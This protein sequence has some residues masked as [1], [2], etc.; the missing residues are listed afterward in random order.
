M[1][2]THGQGTVTIPA[3]PQRVVVLGLA[4]TQ[5]ATALGATIVG[6]TINPSS[7][8]GAWPGVSPQVRP[9]LRTLDSIT[10]NLEA[11][12]GLRPDLILM[13]TAQPSFSAAY[14]EISA[15]APTV[16][17]RTELLQDPGEELVR[18]IGHAL[19]RD[20]EA[21]QLIDR[22]SAT[23][24][25]FRTRHPELDGARY[26]FGQ[27][28]Q[29]G[30]YLVVSPGSPVTALFGDIGLELPA[31]IAGLPVQQAATTQVA[32]E[33]L[34]VLDSADIVF[35]GVG[36]DSDRTAFLSQPLVAASAPARAGR[37]HF[38]TFDQAGLLFQP[39]PANTEAVLGLLE[40]LMSGVGTR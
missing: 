21:Q 39:N 30:T 27:Y 36:A 32:A 14:A 6:A 31:P 17:Y 3:A 4:D 33:N 9:E 26:A 18:I 13:T 15:I 35:L 8:D 29:G 16:S 38:L 1:T 24:A 19:G 34:G 37:L 2:L 20:D 23:L 7:P 11:I 5:I 40:P 22:S 28:V 10:P 25:E 12:A